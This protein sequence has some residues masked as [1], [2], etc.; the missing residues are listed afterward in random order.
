MKDNFEEGCGVL[1]RQQPK[2]ARKDNPEGGKGGGRTVWNK[3]KKGLSRPERRN[4]SSHLEPRCRMN[5]RIVEALNEES[6]Q[7]KKLWRD[8]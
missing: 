4:L 6:I 3:R 1:V 2:A 8:D 7:K 5:Q